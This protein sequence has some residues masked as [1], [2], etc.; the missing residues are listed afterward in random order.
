M[1]ITK[2][3]LENFRQF[4][5]KHIVKL[6]PGFNLIQGPNGTGKSNLLYCV[7]FGFFGVAR[8]KMSVSEDLISFGEEYL[9]VEIE[10]INKGKKYA[11]WRHVTRD[12]SGDGVKFKE[13][14]VA[15][16]KFIDTLKDEKNAI[17][18]EVEKQIGI[19]QTV[20][21]KICYAEQKQYAKIVR[22]EKEFMD[23]V[24]HVIPLSFI[25][26][27]IHEMVLRAPSAEDRGKRYA[28][29][30]TI[31]KNTEED[32]SRATG[33]LTGARDREQRIVRDS[34][35]L[36][37]NNEEFIT[38]DKKLLPIQTTIAMLVTNN[39]I[40]EH[41]TPE[42]K[43]FEQAIQQFEVTKGTKASLDASEESLTV[44][45]ESY[46]K[47][48]DG[49][50]ERKDNE[51]EK[52][53]GIAATIQTNEKLIANMKGLSGK[54]ECPVCKQPVTPQHV[55]SEVA[56]LE[57]V[58]K[59]KKSE[60][61]RIN[62]VIADLDSSISE[63]EQKIDDLSSQ[64][65]Q[66]QLDKKELDGYI[67][68]KNEQQKAVNDASAR[69]KVARSELTTPLTSVITRFNA[70]FKETHT[71]TDTS[72]L[73]DIKDIYDHIKN[74]VNIKMDEYTSEKSKLD[75]D[76]AETQREIATHKQTVDGA[77]KRI[78]DAQDEIKK[79]KV[80]A[81][82][83]AKTTQLEATII[84]LVKEFR[85]QKIADLNKY[86]LDWYKRLVVVPTFRDI[87]IDKE[88]YSVSVLPIQDIVATND[89]KDI[90]WYASGGHETFVGIAERLA[91]IEVF[92]TNFGMF[93]EITDNAD[94]NNAKNL[95]L[96][97]AQSG[98]YLEQI[99][100]VTHF[101][102]GLEVA[103]NIVTVMPINDD[104]GKYTGWSKV[105][106]S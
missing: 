82:V 71:L 102:V 44:E 16:N 81:F 104:T 47:D 43:R 12:G 105:G 33:L 22:G 46:E 77:G 15:N 79:L 100:A 92:G 6:G 72:T 42:V 68:N 55:A 27:T 85:E 30:E 2:I 23:N 48:K 78:A 52:L 14:S 41:S 45:S 60:Q 93:D 56:K 67:K 21:E 61:G 88:D 80:E 11:I 49:M 17:K 3:I 94:K 36:V 99:I 34:S 96:E 19:K 70:V 84:E 75:S 28:G 53:G 26:D 64:I 20:F 74:A 37:K 89:Y 87:R 59:E 83:N 86:T 8:M 38:I 65:R 13:W 40:I 103:G 57:K 106:E 35:A 66:I 29:L 1:Y 101:E 10:F 50:Q 62:K 18:K 9:Q 98:E 4:K 95:I 7:Y 24:L 63:I 39:G 91:L 97:M 76:L 58:L 31:I 51:R 32:V 73:P 25:K 54:P 5:G 90:K 69:F